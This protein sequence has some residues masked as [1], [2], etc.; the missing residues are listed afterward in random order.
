MD[1]I[2]L[3]LQSTKFLAV[4]LISFFL[5]N[6]S[7]FGQPLEIKLTA[8]DGAVGDRFGESVSISGDLAIVGAYDGDLSSSGSAYIFARNLGG[9]DNWGELKKLT[10]S[11][12]AARDAFGFSVS[13]SGDLAMV[14]ANLSGSAYIFA[15]NQGGNDNWGELKKLTA[16]DGVVGDRF[17]ESVSI[18]GDL[19]IVGDHRDDNNGSNSGGGLYLCAQPGRTG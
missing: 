8:S 6:I 5:T 3:N 9:P 18:S 14:G 19:A 12:G 4:F 13:I 16:S 10:A 15:R 17:G 1:K 11:D 2:C 7:V